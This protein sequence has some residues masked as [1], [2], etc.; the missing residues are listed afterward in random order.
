[1]D[2]AIKYSDSIILLSKSVDADSVKSPVKML[3]LLPFVKKFFNFFLF[4]LK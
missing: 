2:Y 1:M 4:S 3:K